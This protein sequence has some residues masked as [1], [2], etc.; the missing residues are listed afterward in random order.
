MYLEDD[1]Q[2]L[3]KQN[4]KPAMAAIETARFLILIDYQQVH[5]NPPRIIKSEKDNQDPL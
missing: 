5:L 2:W 3:K 1:K 4:M